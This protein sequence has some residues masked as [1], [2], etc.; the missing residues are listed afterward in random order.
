MDSITVSAPAKVNLFLEVYGLKPNGYHDIESIMQ[1]VSLCDTLEIKRADSKITLECSDEKLPC[2]STNLVVRAAAAFFCEAGITGG[3]SFRLDKAIPVA[4][5]LAGG[6]SDAAAAI[7]GLN[8]LYGTSLSLKQLCAVG[9]LIGSDVAFCI[10]RGTCQASGSG[11]A[12]Q[13]CPDLPDC[14]IVVA[15]GAGRVSTRWA[16][17]RIDDMTGRERRPIDGIRAAIDGG[18]IAGVAANLYNAFETVSPHETAI[19]HA[20]LEHGALGA[21][22]SGSGPAVFGIFSGE[23]AAQ[24]A[25]GA[26]SASGYTSFVCRPYSKHEAGD[27]N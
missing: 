4:A 12:L 13:R 21:S 26:L 14:R 17:H 8:K 2:D 9:A 27:R 11:E 19:K 18:D 20:L 1:T 24:A 3:A 16:F 6:S 7:I 15:V 22:M 25:H 23:A 5:G 10:R